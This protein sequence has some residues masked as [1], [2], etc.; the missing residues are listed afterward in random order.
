MSST[1]SKA[2]RRARAELQAA[3]SHLSR[4]NYLRLGLVAETPSSSCPNIVAF[5]LYGRGER[6]FRGA[7]LNVQSY[8]RYFPEYTCRFYVASDIPR[9]LVDELHCA[10]A[11]VVVIASTGVDHYY[12]FWR[13]HAAQDPAIDNYLI[14]DIDSTASQRERDL[15]EEF[16]SSQRDFWIVRDHYSH[17]SR[18]M[19]GLW[20]GRRRLRMEQWIRRGLW[21]YSNDWS[22]DQRFLSRVVYPRIVERALVHDVVRR[23]PDEKPVLTRV[24]TESWSFMG[25]IATSH[26]TR[27]EWRNEFRRLHLAHSAKQLQREIE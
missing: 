1:L 14:R 15:Y 5:S 7:L 21:R 20:G 19:A 17:N 8:G 22:R 12:K 27:D 23:F 2:V 3:P 13:F 9:R 6:Y 26:R 16:I 4:F 10:G 24:D 25:E 11:E 18:I